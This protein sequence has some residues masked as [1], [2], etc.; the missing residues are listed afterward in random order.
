MVFG[1]LDE[2]NAG[3]VTVFR[4]VLKIDDSAPRA[5]GL[6]VHDNREIIGLTREEE[7]PRLNLHPTKANVGSLSNS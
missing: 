7:I 3:S 4:L 5:D 2:R 6:A 1:H